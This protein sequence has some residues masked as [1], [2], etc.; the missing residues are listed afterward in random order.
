M[1]KYQV[2]QVDQIVSV[3]DPNGRGYYVPWGMGDGTTISDPIIIKLREHFKCIPLTVSQ[4]EAKIRELEVEAPITVKDYVV[5]KK[6]FGG[7]I[8]V[9][10]KD[11]Q[12]WNITDIPASSFKDYDLAIAHLRKKY[13]GNKPTVKEVADEL[14]SYLNPTRLVVGEYTL[15]S[16]GSYCG[17]DKNHTRIK[18]AGIK[19]FFTFNKSCSVYGVG[20]KE[21][22]ILDELNE[23]GLLKIR[24]VANFLETFKYA[25]PDKFNLKQTEMFADTPI[26]VYCRDGS[27]YHNGY[28]IGFAATQGE[29]DALVSIVNRKSS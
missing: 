6:E 22:K 14:K 16:Y 4:V 13:F 8:R 29:L 2:K 18:K 21:K 27:V 10:D 15:E 28:R 9:T 17:D 19:D 12:G 1:S 23:K 24:D 5:S 7:G 25:P 26:S 11:N 3:T 20:D